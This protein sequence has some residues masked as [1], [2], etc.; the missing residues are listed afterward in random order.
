MVLD[1]SPSAVDTGFKWG[2]ARFILE[3]RNPDLETKRHAAGEIC[4]TIDTVPVLH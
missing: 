1:L 3:Q 4:F 2:G